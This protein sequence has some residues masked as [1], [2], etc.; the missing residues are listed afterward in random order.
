MARGG[1]RA[2]GR[3]EA[4]RAGVVAGDGLDGLDAGVAGLLR[5]LDALRGDFSNVHIA[6]GR[7]ALALVLHRIL[8]KMVVVSIA[9][10]HQR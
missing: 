3:A 8:L 9:C 2:L 10:S 5:G 6:G 1:R 7:R 4:R